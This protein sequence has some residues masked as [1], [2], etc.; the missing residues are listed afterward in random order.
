MVVNQTCHSLPVPLQTI[1]WKKYR[2]VRIWNLCLGCCHGS[3]TNPGE[4]NCDPKLWSG[5]LCDHPVC[6][7]GCDFTHGYCNKPNT[8]I[9][10]P[11]WQGDNCT[12]CAPYPYCKT[13]HTLDTGACVD[14]W[15]CLCKGVCNVCMYVMFSWFTLF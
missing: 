4:C 12:E 10:K 8:C 2:M 15:E 5:H 1:F 9:C 11:G 7:E 14:P 6:S 3:C 13:D